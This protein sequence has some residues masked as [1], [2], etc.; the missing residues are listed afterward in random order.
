MTTEMQ[1]NSTIIH[2]VTPEEIAALFEGLQNQLAEIKQNFEPKTPVEYLT[3]S[4]VAKKL[5]CD[6]STVHNW[7]KSGKLKPYSIGNRIYY[8]LS[9]VE[10]ALIPLGKNHDVI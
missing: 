5:K 1:K 8:K 10:A 3:R 4:E 7:T 2:D 6:L 9:E